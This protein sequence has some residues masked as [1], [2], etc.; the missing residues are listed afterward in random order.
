MPN[1]VGSLSHQQHHRLILKV[2]CYRHDFVI[3]VAA[4]PRLA[5]IQAAPEP[6]A[7]VVQHDFMTIEVGE[8]RRISGADL[9]LCC[10]SD[11]AAAYTAKVRQNPRIHLM[12]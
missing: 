6:V 2:K 8:I 5:Q 11:V 10:E 3:I 1:P 9:A 7:V 12:V 4:E